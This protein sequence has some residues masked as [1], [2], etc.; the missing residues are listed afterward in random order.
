[1]PDYSRTVIYKLC[2]KDTNIKDIYIGST[3]NFK[4]R[5]SS[6]KSNCYN[7]NIRNY[8]LKVYQF[9]RDNGGFVNW[10]MI[11]LFE[12]PECQNKLQ[13]ESKEREYIELFKPSLNIKIP[14]K[15]KI[16]YREN[17]KE[18]INQKKKQYYIDNKDVI[19]DKHKEHYNKNK[20]IISECGS[21]IRISDKSAHFKTIK[22][23]NYI[24]ENNNICLS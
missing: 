3:C 1:M 5:K 18:L 15:T 10:S 8:N 2:C 21:N 16:E 9:M 19:K 6:H 7:T 23:L 12:Y 4:R 20:E 14:T 13:K 11:M 24:N 17:N 22:H